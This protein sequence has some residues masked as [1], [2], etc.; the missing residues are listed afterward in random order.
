MCTCVYL[1]LHVNANVQH[2]REVKVQLLLYPT[3]VLK[4][5]YHR[6]ATPRLKFYICIYTKSTFI[7]YFFAY[8]SVY[9]YVRA[10]MRLFNI[11]T[12]YLKNYRNNSYNNCKSS[13]SRSSTIGEAV[14]FAVISS[15][16]KNN[17]SN[18]IKGTDHS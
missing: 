18:N 9:M 11:R 1:C 4:G 15:T 14:G 13:F 2:L 12:I 5:S 6:F 3:T 8:T 7:I 17:H 16:S 10:C